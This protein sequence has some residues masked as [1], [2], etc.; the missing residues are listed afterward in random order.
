MGRPTTWILQSVPDENV[1]SKA[2]ADSDVTN[3]GKV[4]DD[5]VHLKNIQ[6]FETR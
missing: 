5:L 1:R 4:V 6:T 3:D 2:D